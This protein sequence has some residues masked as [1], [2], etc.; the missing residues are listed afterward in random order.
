[1]PSI[2]GEIANCKIQVIHKMFGLKAL[3]N[4]TLIAPNI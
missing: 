4:P 3:G 2:Y 1:M